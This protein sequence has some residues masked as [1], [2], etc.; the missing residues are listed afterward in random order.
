[1]QFFLAEPAKEGE[2]GFMNQ[3]KYMRESSKWM[4][5]ALRMHSLGN[6]TPEEALAFQSLSPKQKRLYSNRIRN[7]LDGKSKGPMPQIPGRNRSK[8]S[9][10]DASCAD[11]V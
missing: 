4:R 9:E 11:K 1:M 2:H 8:R 5:M 6:R 7:W 3:D 10:G